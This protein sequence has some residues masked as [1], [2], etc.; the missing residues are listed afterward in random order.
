MNIRAIALAV[1]SAFLAGLAF[2]HAPTRTLTRHTGCR[3]CLLWW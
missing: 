1:V 3:S 2:A